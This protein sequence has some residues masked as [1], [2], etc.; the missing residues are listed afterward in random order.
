MTPW[1][2]CIAVTSKG[3]FRT[4]HAVELRNSYDLIEQGGR[5]YYFRDRSDVWKWEVPVEF[6][7]FYPKGVYVKAKP[8]T[9]EA[10]PKIGPSEMSKLKELSRGFSAVIAVGFV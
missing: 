6:E 5:P 2:C 1:H 3:Q 10:A 9:G 4:A 7:F 8:A